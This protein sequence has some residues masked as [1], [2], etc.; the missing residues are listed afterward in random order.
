MFFAR[1]QAHR[2]A[3][4]RKASSSS[5]SPSHSSSVCRRVRALRRRTT[6]WS[7][8][9]AGK[10]MIDALPSEE[11]PSR[12]P[13]NQ[14]TYSGLKPRMV[15]CRLLAPTGHVA[16]SGDHE[17]TE[18]ACPQPEVMCWACENC[19]LPRTRR[20]ALGALVKPRRAGVGPGDVLNTWDMKCKTEKPQLPKFLA[21]WTFLA[22]ERQFSRGS[23]H[24]YM[25]TTCT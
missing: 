2:G 23:H 3:P 7:N 12:G 18:T 4:S 13:R 25:S 22:S 9:R 20:W 10:Q 1:L 16:Q 21:Y 19:P 5:S 14:S 17:G 15:F 24:I 8:P 11:A 6:R